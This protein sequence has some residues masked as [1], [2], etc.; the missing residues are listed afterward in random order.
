[1]RSY[2]TWRSLV[3]PACLPAAGTCCVT[4]DGGLLVWMSAGCDGALKDLVNNPMSGSF[5]IG[6][7]L[8]FPMTKTFLR[9]RD[10]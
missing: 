5:Q 1:M 8:A 6:T 2:W 3:V 7:L 10:A 4:T 9:G